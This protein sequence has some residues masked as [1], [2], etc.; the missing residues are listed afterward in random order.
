M[1]LHHVPGKFNVVAAALP[2]HL[3]LAKIVGSVESGWL[4]QI[5]EAYTTA[6]S[7]SWE[8]LKKIRNFCEHGFI[9]HDSLL[10]SMHSEN[11]V[12]LVIPEDAGLWT[13]LLR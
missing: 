10:C 3:D 12:N 5:Q 7:D 6:S 8:Y 9:F 13:D 4:T 11:K 1:T 2:H